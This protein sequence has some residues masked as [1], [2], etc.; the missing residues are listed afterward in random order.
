MQSRDGRYRIVEPSFAYE[1]ASLTFGFPTTRELYRLHPDQTGSFG[2]EGLEWYFETSASYSR[3]SVSG[4]NHIYDLSSALSRY[5]LVVIRVYWDNGELTIFYKQD[6]GSW[7][8]R[9]RTGSFSAVAPRFSNDQNAVYI[10]FPT[11][12]GEYVLRNNGTGSYGNEGFVWYY[13]FSDA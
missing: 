11:T 5:M 6:D 4:S 12:T 7:M 13:N 9:G 1:G 10:S 2:Q 3:G 8:M